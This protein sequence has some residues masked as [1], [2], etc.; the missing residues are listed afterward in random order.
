MF[1][2]ATNQKSSR[3]GLTVSVPFTPH[4][5]VKISYSDGA[6]VRYGGNY[7]S[8]TLA[9]QFAWIGWRFH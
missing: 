2:P 9:W 5:S 7:Q 1:N 4:Q 6:Y 3:V 8:V